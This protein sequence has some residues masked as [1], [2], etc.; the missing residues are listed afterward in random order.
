[1]LSS[2]QS[3]VRL[4]REQC[5]EVELHNE[6]SGGHPH[7]H[8]YGGVE[9]WGDELSGTAVTLIAVILALKLIDCSFPR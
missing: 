5:S 3:S 8:D 7:A 9:V 2:R 6:G 4:D 1:M